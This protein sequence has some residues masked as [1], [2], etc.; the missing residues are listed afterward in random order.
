MHLTATRVTAI[1][2]RKHVLGGRKESGSLY[3]AGGDVTQAAATQLNVEPPRK[4]SKH[5]E[6][7]REGLSLGPEPAGIQTKCTR[8]S[9]TPTRESTIISI[10]KGI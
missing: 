5:P 7:W 10:R 2:T 4:H 9:I 8:T 6:E 1:T 3:V